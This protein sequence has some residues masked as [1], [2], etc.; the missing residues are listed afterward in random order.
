MKT[1][2]YTLFFAS[3]F[4][5]IACEKDK[6]VISDSTWIASSIKFENGDFANPNSQYYLVFE[7]KGQYRLQLDI[8]LCGGEISFKEKSVKF[9]NGMGCTEACCDSDFAIALVDNLTK[10]KNWVLN[11]NQLVFTNDKG[12][13]IIF[14]KK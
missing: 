10:T 11:A 1:I 8:N 2:F 3:F 4:F 6:D 7:H 5:L 9:K 13:E 12:L 14:V